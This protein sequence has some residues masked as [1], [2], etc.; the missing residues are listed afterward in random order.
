MAE[1]V[2]P[3]TVSFVNQPKQTGI[4]EYISIEPQGNFLSNC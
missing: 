3:K 2:K 4:E 1:P